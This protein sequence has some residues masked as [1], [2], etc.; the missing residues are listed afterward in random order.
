MASVSA[1]GSAT[2]LKRLQKEFIK[3]QKSPPPG[4]SA[5]PR[6]KSNGEQNWLVWDCIIIGP[7]DSPY[8]DGVFRAEIVVP[9]QY[10]MLPVRSNR[11][12]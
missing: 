12:H 1:R 6:L 4:I 2:A 8:E 3:M 7:P 5:A 9:R 11:A 10:P